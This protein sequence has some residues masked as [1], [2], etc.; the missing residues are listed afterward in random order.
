MYGILNETK[1]G[2][3]EKH[4]FERVLEALDLILNG[5]ISVN[6]SV[7]LFFPV[8]YVRVI[9][10]RTT[11]KVVRLEVKSSSRKRGLRR[12]DVSRKLFFASFHPNTHP[13]HCCFRRSAASMA[14]TLTQAA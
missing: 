4:Q 13:V 9:C 1:R 10:I 11:T 8:N 14:A 7:C 12:K 5:G 6:R 3:L 2:M